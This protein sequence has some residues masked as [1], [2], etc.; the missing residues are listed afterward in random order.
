M[1][2]AILFVNRLAGCTLLF[3]FP[4]ENIIKRANDFICPLDIIFSFDLSSW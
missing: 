2:P 4:D 1:Q 3:L